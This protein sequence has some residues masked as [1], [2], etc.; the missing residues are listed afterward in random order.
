MLYASIFLILLVCR[1]ARKKDT[2]TKDTAMM[3][4]PETGIVKFHFTSPNMC[5]NVDM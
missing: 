5:M 2:M 4:T 3:T 1:R